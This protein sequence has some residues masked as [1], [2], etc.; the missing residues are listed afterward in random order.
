MGTGTLIGLL[1]NL[2][3]RAK[4]IEAIFDQETTAFSSIE[5]S[6]Q[7]LAATTA[8]QRYLGA[9]DP[10]IDNYANTIAYLRAIL[11]GV[12]SFQHPEVTRVPLRRAI[13]PGDMTPWTLYPSDGVTFFSVASPYPALAPLDAS[14]HYPPF[15]APAPFFNF[16]NRSGLIQTAEAFAFGGSHEQTPVVQLD[17]T[18]QIPRYSYF[19]TG[20]PPP[21]AGFGIVD[22]PPTDSTFTGIW[23]Q[24]FNPGDGWLSTPWVRPWPLTVI[25]GNGSAPQTFSIPSMQVP[26]GD[27]QPGGI[28]ISWNRRRIAVYLFRGQRG[29][30]TQPGPVPQ[31]WLYPFFPWDWSYPYPYLEQYPLQAW[32][33]TAYYTGVYPLVVPPPLPVK[34]S[35]NWPGILSSE[36]DVELIP[37]FPATSGVDST[38]IPPFTGIPPLVTPI[39]SADTT[40]WTNGQTYTRPISYGG[41]LPTTGGRLAGGS[42]SSGPW[43]AASVGVSSWATQMPDGN[44]ALIAQVIQSWTAI[45]QTLY[46][47]NP[48]IYAAD[49]A[50]LVNQLSQ[51]VWTTTVGQVYLTAYI[52]SLATTANLAYQYV[53]LY[54]AYPI[55]D[56]RTGTK[57]IIDPSVLLCET[58]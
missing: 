41:R 46:P 24:P 43:S 28:T 6:V 21:G 58:L 53:A 23:V 54:G 13:I 44:A 39:L 55:N 37:W 15:G 17:V 4:G 38:N 56:P 9:T 49:L 51:P 34:V 36:I 2:F 8:Q 19:G 47:T 45:N 18:F 35:M 1:E 5:Q 22:K 40:V 48:E 12:Q 52:D 7:S 11:A 10:S 27:A 29:L 32:G 57:A 26:S 25:I 14:G 30:M 42:W 50:A 3:S 16:P 31:W 20:M 33:E